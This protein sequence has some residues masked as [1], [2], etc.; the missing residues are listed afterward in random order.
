MSAENLCTTYYLVLLFSMWTPALRC[1][2]Y[3]FTCLCLTLCALHRRSLLCYFQ[4]GWLIY[5]E[6]AMDELPILISHAYWLFILPS[7]IIGR[8]L[9]PAP[10]LLAR[11]HIFYILIQTLTTYI[12]PV[13]QIVKAF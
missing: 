3:L 13:I 2:V 8:P 10:L 6:M 4:F 5:D 7:C 9:G 12:A 11:P 1:G